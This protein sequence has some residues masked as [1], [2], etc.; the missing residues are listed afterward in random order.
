M[1]NNIRGNL[2]CLARELAFQTM[3]YDRGQRFDARYTLQNGNSVVMGVWWRSVSGRV[4]V[5]L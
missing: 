1:T 2:Y 4:S 5:E 3:L